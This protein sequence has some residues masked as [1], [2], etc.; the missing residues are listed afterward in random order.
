MSENPFRS[1]QLLFGNRMVGTSNLVERIAAS[2]HAQAE[3][4][5]VKKGKLEYRSSISKPHTNTDIS[6]RVRTNR[7]SAAASRARIFCYA[8]EL[9]KCADRLEEERNKYYIKSEQHGK[10][11]GENVKLRNVFQKLWDMKEPTISRVIISP[12]ASSENGE[13]LPSK[14]AISSPPHSIPGNKR[15]TVVGRES[16]NGAPAEKLN[17][18]SDE[19]PQY[20]HFR[21]Y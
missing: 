8:S 17:N 7:A 5:R 2:K 11:I 20:L 19:L 15:N 16:W 13:I 10:T 4:E 12:T 9:E 21:F 14:P 18:H 3:F 1:R 6:T